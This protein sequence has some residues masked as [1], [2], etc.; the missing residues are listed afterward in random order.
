MCITAVADISFGISKSIVICYISNV[1]DIS[2][3]IS[4][5]IVICYISNVADVSLIMKGCMLLMT[6]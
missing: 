1:A 4:K 2:F 6:Q 3:G 5:S